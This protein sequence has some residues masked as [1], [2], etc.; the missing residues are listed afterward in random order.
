M[1]TRERR[2]GKTLGKAIRAARK[3]RGMTQTDL[4]NECERLGRY[5]SLRTIHRL[6]AD[7]VNGS[8]RIDDIR[9]VA[10]A[11][12]VRLEALIPA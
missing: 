6:E 4:S 9:V 11:L 10:R 12:K 2:Q 1:T 7:D 5:I 3:A 8:P